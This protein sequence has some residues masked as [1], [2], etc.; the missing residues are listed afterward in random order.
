MKKPRS[1]SKLL[2]LPEEKQAQLAEWLLSGVP[3]HQALKLIEK[4]FQ[5]TT[6]FAALSAFWT[7]VCTPALLARRQQAVTTADSVAAD[8]KKMP[9][10]F[11]A[12]TI[13]AI[14]QKAFELSVSPQAAPGE[15]KALF[16]LLLKSRDQEL[17][18][19]QLLL[20]KQRFEFDAAKAALAALPDL[21][22][23]AADKGLNEND[24]IDA[25]RRR[26]F[27][28]IPDEK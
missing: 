23:I 14:R 6:S 9:G 12:A 18:K 16:M 19:D 3:Y 1:D 4:E 5:L 27:G 24:R 25:I 2:N 10:N 20:D 26:L 7:D 21:R 17:K 13:D 15:V 28:Q 22:A 8:A 11:D